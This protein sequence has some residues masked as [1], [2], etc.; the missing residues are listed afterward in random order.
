MACHPMSL[1]DN[2]GA[3]RNCK[4]FDKVF[5]EIFGAWVIIVLSYQETPGDF[6]PELHRLP[7]LCS[8]CSKL[9]V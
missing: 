5:N 8:I 2:L 1:S 9:G 7:M 6:L 4:R 3:L